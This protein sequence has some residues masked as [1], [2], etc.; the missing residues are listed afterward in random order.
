M[1][2]ISLLAGLLVL[3]R[4][5]GS[6]VISLLG[7]LALGAQRLLPA[8]QQIYSGWA[9]LKGSSAAIHAVLVMLEQPL[10]PLVKA[11]SHSCCWIISVSKEYI[12]VMIAITLMF[13]GPGS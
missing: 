4:G 10:P 12:S 5:S 8:L 2:V 1:V 7:V 9:S 3:Q 6:S 11:P 13:E